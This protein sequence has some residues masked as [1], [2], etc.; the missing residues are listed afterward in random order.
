MIHEPLRAAQ[1]RSCMRRRGAH[2]EAHRV[3]MRWRDVDGAGVAAA[4]Y[5]FFHVEAIAIDRNRN[6]S[7]AGHRE[8]LLRAGIA[9]LFDPDGVVQIQQDCARKP[10]GPIA[11]R[12]RRLLAKR[13]SA[14]HEMR[15]DIRRLLRGTA[16]NP[17]DRRRPS[18]RAWNFARGARGAR[19]KRRR[20][21][22]RAPGG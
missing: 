13:R 19:T 6:E 2:R 15:R 22:N 5:S 4:A 3:L 17:S 7:G 18:F 8:S 14:R 20:G 1:L 11:S 16:R 9:R 10:A 21:N 12:G